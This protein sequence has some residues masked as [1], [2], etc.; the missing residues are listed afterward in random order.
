MNIYLLRP[1][2]TE[3]GPWK[4]WYDKA[5]G[6]VVR[7]ANEEEARRFASLEHGDEGQFPWFDKLATSCEILNGEGP[8]GVIIKDYARA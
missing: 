4:P 2:N 5:F 8:E 3:S 1:F 6:F 7:A